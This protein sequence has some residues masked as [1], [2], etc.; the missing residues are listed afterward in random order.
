MIFKR[1]LRKHGVVRTSVFFCR[2]LG[3]CNNL[4]ELQAT[5]SR[6]HQPLKPVW[7]YILAGATTDHG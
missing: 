6:P 7:P 5:H 4:W 3:Q 1:L 2:H